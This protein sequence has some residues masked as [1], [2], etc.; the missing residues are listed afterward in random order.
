[1]AKKLLEEGTVRRFMKIAGLQPLSE[2]FVDNLEE[3]VVEEKK[4]EE[5]KEKMEEGY[6]EAEEG[7]EPMK[8]EAE[9]EMDAPADEMAPEPEAAEDEEI[10]MDMG[11]EGMMDED[12]KVDLLQKLAQALGVDVE[13]EAD[14]EGG[15]EEKEE[16]PEAPEADMEEPEAAGEEEMMEEGEHMEGE[17]KAKPNGD[18]APDD[19]DMQPLKASTT[20]MAESREAFKNRL[21]EQVAKRVA[22]RLKELK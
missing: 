12:E 19:K 7:M 6:D 9:E 15:E 10:E 3:E 2:G 16:A 13:V 18:V 1:M 8:E 11:D 20:H 5:D 4:E 21:V 14:E 17:E 22:E